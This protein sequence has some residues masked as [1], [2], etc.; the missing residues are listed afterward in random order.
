MEQFLKIK[1][2]ETYSVS[3]YGNIRNDL[4]EVY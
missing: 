4:Q 2:Y 1:D 3:N